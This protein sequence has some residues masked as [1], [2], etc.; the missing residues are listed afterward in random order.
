MKRLPPCLALPLL[1]GS[2]F[3]APLPNA[4][5]GD[6][7]LADYL[8]NETAALSE[9]CLADIKT[10][11]DWQSQRAE[12]RRQLAEMLGLWAT[13]EA[14]D[15][16]SVITGKLESDEFTVEKLQFQASPH[17]Y[18][19]ANFYLPRKIEK[20]LPTILLE[21]GHA[22]VMTNGISYGNKAAYQNL[23]A[24]FARNGYACLVLDTLLLGEIQGLHV[25]TR[26]LGQWWWNSRGYTPAGV[27]AWFGIRAL[28]YLGT[29]PEVDTNRFGITGHSGGGAYS[30]TVG[31]LDERIKAAAPMA[32]LTDL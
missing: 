5:R 17:L 11:D 6:A 31:A 19:T 14:T 30:W 3:A 7:M 2:L 10:C 1:A 27:E 29:R 26:D 23:G 4:T 22:R 9:R 18:V 28:D 24:W 13:P 25:G 15:L 21:C 8:C 20:P 12:Y 16:Q 32:G